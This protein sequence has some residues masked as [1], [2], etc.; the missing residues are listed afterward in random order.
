MDIYSDLANSA[1]LEIGSY[2]VNGALRDHAAPTTKYVGVDMEQ[3]PGVDLVVT[4]GEALP[5]EDESFDLVM[6]SSVF[7]HD[8]CFWKTFLEMCRTVRTGGYIYISA[9]SNG[10]FH[11]YPRD[12]WRFYPDCGEAFVAWAAAHDI[13]VLLVESFV[14]DRKAEV[15]ND[16]VAVFRKGSG[17][18][19]LPDDFIYK[20][21]MAYNVHVWNSAELVHPREQTEDMV[22]IAAMRS[23]IA[24]LKAAVDQG[25]MR[26]QAADKARDEAVLKV[27][28]Q[29]EAA[30]KAWVERCV[31]EQLLRKT[32]EDL[33]AAQ[34]QGSDAL[35]DAHALRRELATAEQALL[36]LRD[37]AA[38]MGVARDKMQQDFEQQLASSEAIRFALEDRVRT[39]S[40]DLEVA[41]RELD[42][43]SS[44]SDAQSAEL[45][46]T[47]DQHARHARWLEDVAVVLAAEPWW[48]GLVPAGWHRSLRDRKL[49]EMGLFD[50]GEY[51][52]INKDVE[53]SGMDPLVH[54]VR[55][56]IKE[57]RGGIHSIP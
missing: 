40:V 27:Q 37:E 34:Q 36:R 52:K 6:A 21:C 51:L 45:R 33:R 43:R 26:I 44:A 41:R 25:N 48:W 29:E 12:H 47:L 49:H 9:P 32:E 50:A 42:E 23:E 7:E 31:V 22:L 35:Q 57:N 11:R 24:R 53:S 38:G 2:N 30:Q 17:T 15:Y 46:S 39:L 1:I 8:P 3:G 4:P 56:G 28:Q 55:H 18:E 19:G 10:T 54:Y 5:F 13:E 14:A 16:F 20:K